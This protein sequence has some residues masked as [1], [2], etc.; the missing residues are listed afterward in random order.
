MNKPL[1]TFR[2]RFV[3]DVKKALIINLDI[4]GTNFQ[5]AA[6]NVLKEFEKIGE[7]WDCWNFVLSGE[8]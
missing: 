3:H 7:N 2:F 4:Q 1:K 5:H 8:I 6:L